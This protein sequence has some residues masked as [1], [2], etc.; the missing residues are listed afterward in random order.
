M[1]W[2]PDEPRSKR[3]SGE[4]RPVADQ[5][6]DGVRTFVSTIS[7]PRPCTTTPT[8]SPASSASNHPRCLSVRRDD[9]VEVDELRDAIARAIRDAGDDHLWMS[10]PVPCLYVRARTTN[11]VPPFTGTPTQRRSSASTKSAS[12]V[13]GVASSRRGPSPPSTCT[14]VPFTR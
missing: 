11:V 9:R 5:G 1:A 4:E 12:E 7:A 10:F 2:E 13:A 6:L 8:W 14:A 3:A